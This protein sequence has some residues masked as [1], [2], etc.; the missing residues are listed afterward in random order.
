MIIVKVTWSMNNFWTISNSLT[1]QF[2]LCKTWLQYYSIPLQALNCLIT[3]SMGAL[4]IGQGSPL[5]FNTC[6][7][8]K[9]QQQCPVSPWITV[10]FL[11]CSMQIMHLELSSVASG[12]ATVLPFSVTKDRAVS[13][14]EGDV[15]RSLISQGFSSGWRLKLKPT[16][17]TEKSY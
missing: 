16:R 6:A 11:G 7:Q 12:A 17:I 4:Q 5:C 3:C 8:A 1:G 14:S 9:Q 10:A 15:K 2:G 13:P